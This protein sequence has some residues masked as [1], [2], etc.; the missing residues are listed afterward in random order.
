MT[1][2]GR[3]AYHLRQLELGKESP[4]AEEFKVIEEIKEEPKTK[5][6]EKK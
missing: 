6:K 2:E 3:K 1:K 5:S 4:Y